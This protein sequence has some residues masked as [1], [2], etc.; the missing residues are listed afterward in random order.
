MGT[1]RP[2]GFR[3]HRWASVGGGEE[4][5]GA[6]RDVGDPFAQPHLDGRVDTGVGRWPCGCSERPGR[7]RALGASGC[8][9]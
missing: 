1:S 7:G 9:W 8:R 3:L 2:R 5:A 6:Q 4:W